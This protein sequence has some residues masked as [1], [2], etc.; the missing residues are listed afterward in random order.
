MQ[1]SR[2]EL[3]NLLKFVHDQSFATS[4]PLL[5][6]LF[7]KKNKKQIFQEKNDRIKEK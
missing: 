3:L 2:F 5:L 7:I 1:S 6:R 4:I